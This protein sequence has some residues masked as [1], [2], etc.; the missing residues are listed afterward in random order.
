MAET[1]TVAETDEP[2]MAEGLAQKIV[3]CDVQLLV[4][5]EYCSVAVDR[6]SDGVID[7]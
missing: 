3:V 2:E 6:E 5:H 1:V 7:V 4:L